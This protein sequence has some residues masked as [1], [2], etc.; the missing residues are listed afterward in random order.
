VTTGDLVV[1]HG[2]TQGSPMDPLLKST[3]SPE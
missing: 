1:E 3:K 2:G